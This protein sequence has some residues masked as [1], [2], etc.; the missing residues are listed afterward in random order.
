MSKRG[1]MLSGEY[2]FMTRKTNGV[3]DFD[4]MPDDRETDED[5]YHYIVKHS[6]FLSRQWGS[7]IVVDRVSDNRYF[8]DFGTSL[9]QTSLQFLRSFGTF[10]GVGRYWDFELMV[11]DFQILDDT[12]TP[13]NRPYR[14]LPRL[15]FA[16]DQ[17]LAGTGL[18]FGLDSEL[19]NFDRDLGTTGTRMDF[20]PRM[21]WSKY[22]SWGFIKPSLG[23]RYTTYDLNLQGAPGEETPDRS[24]MIASL[25]SGL[26]F[27][28]TTAGGNVQT[29]EPRLFY[30]YVPYKDQDQLPDFD[31]GE[32]TFGYSQLFNT[33]RFAGADRQGD[34]N[35]LSLAVTTN[36]YNG[37][38]GEV[39]WSLSLGQIFYFKDRRVQLGDRPPATADTSPFLGE[40]AWHLWSNFSAIAG[41]QWDWDH[42]EVMVGS[43]GFNYRGDKGERLRFEYRYRK[44]RVDQFDLRFFWP[45]NERWRV[46]SRVN[47]SFADSDLLE[48]QG[49]LEYESCCWA[50]RT[51]LRRY[52]KNRDGDYRDGIYFEL[53]LKGLTS[54]GNRNQRLFYD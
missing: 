12:I 1:F 28:R 24:T 49:G 13:Q 37:V 29:L 43:V 42:A 3:L 39:L 11:D 30:L 46:L 31:T 33:N 22:S 6:T 38:S 35:Q 51:V 23:L 41:L 48:V 34:A 18:F 52:L 10:T 54:V 19:V 5:R 7:R 20:Y 27:D 44:D 32:F 47:Y 40:F 50:L 4:Y 2:R 17:P 9:A 16:V 26:V 25:D 14:R 45:I 36:H 53:N 21:Y 15:L 8:Q